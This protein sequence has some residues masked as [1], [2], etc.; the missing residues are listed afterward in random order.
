MFAISGSGHISE[1]FIKLYGIF[2][3]YKMKD[4]QNLFKF[5]TSK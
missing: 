2:I 3:I 5:S 1:S 4:G